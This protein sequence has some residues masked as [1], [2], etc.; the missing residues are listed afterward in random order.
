MARVR[1]AAVKLFDPRT[2]SH[3]KKLFRIPKNV[4]N[5]LYLLTFSD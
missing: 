2:P 1:V 3:S 4:L 5:G